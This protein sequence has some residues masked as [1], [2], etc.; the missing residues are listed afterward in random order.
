MIVKGFIWRFGVPL[1]AVLAAL[2]FAPH[3]GQANRSSD[4]ARPAPDDAEA[5]L[6]PSGRMYQAGADAIDA[7][8]YEVAIKVLRKAVQADPTHADAFNLLGY[9]YRHLQDYEVAIDH[10]QEALRL[11]PEHSGVHHYLGETYLELGDLARAE[12]H[13][14]QLDLICL[15][16]CADFYELAEAVA[17]F[18]NNQRL[19]AADQQ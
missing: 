2:C 9:A 14:R 13:L 10:Y 6:T 3:D 4:Q 5:V 16:G 11:D 7:G 18:R 17:L 8:Q 19:S 12:D 1:A 15:F